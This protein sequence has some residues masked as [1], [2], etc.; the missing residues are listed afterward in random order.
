MCPD[1][2]LKWFKDHGHS[3]SQIHDIRNLVATRWNETCKGDEGPEL[4]PHAVPWRGKVSAKCFMTLSLYNYN[5]IAAQ[6]KVGC[7]TG[8]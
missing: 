2:K 3:D 7:F 6:I 1:K 5:L 8:L 4:A